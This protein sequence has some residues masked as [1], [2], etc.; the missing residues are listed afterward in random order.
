MCTYLLLISGATWFGKELGVVPPEDWRD[1]VDA[2]SGERGLLRGKRD[3]RGYQIECLGGTAEQHH[4]E[5]EIA[6]GGTGPCFRGG[7]YGKLGWN[8]T[9]C[10]DPTNCHDRDAL[11]KNLIDRRKQY[12]FAVARDELN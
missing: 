4:R 10:E 9:R 5:G 3:T 11:E 2:Y 8:R 1:A 7:Q 12:T 6:H